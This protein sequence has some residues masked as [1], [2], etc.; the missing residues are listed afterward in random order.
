[1][2]GVSIIVTKFVEQPILR[3]LHK[4]DEVRKIWWTEETAFAAAEERIDAVTVRHRDETS[5]HIMLNRRR[6]FCNTYPPFK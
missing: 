6:V 3:I 4:L 1:V 2:Y 5:N